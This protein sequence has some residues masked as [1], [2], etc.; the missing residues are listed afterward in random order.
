MLEE[1][2]FYKSC[3]SSSK[4]YKTHTSNQEMGLFH[5]FRLR[6]QE[7]FFYKSCLVS[8]KEYKTGFS[9]Q[10]MELSNRKWN[11]LSLLDLC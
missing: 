9:K 10:E 1:N 8:S 2:F 6:L 5:T 3:L 4:E 7:N 11:Y